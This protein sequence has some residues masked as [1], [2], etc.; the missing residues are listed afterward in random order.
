MNTTRKAL[1]V[2]ASLIAPIAPAFA[3]DTTM[4]HK[5]ASYIPMTAA[6]G[7]AIDL[8]TFLA[9]AAPLVKATEPGTEVWFALQ[10]ETEKHVAIFDVFRDVAAQDEHFSGKVAGALN[11]Q[12][13]D[14]VDGGWND[15]VVAN[16]RGSEVLSESVPLNIEDATTATYISIRAATGQGDALA[17]LLTAAGAVVADTEPQTLY[18]VA[19]RLDQHNFA[20]FDIFANQSG[21]EA[22]FAGKVA[23]LLKEHSAEL[24]DGG[25]DEGVVANISNFKILASK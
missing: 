7:K 18:W 25:W 19:L 13:S 15:G 21:R 8:A 14:L 3:K 23:G 17:N 9:G 5:T 22:H 11:D 12:A 16:I 2:A 1:L 10:A 20:L 24:V 6:P 4:T